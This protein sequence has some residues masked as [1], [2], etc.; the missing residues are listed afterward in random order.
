MYIIYPGRHVGGIHGHFQIFLAF[1]RAKF[2]FFHVRHVIGKQYVPDQGSLLVAYG[3]DLDS[4]NHGVLVV[5]S[6]VCL[7]V[8]F[9][10]IVF[11]F[12]GNFLPSLYFPQ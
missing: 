12:Q 4:V 5:S 6:E 9:V 3:N 8:Y 10:E 2:R 7:A 1:F 11:K